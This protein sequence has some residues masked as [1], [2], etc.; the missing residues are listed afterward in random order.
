MES[1]L[2]DVHYAIR[3]LLRRPAFTSLAVLTL[4]ARTVDVLGMIL[5]SGMKLA[6]AGVA[7]GVVAAFALTRVIRSLGNGRLTHLLCSVGARCL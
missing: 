1:S 4:G 3:A 6:L 5:K 2:K 7:V